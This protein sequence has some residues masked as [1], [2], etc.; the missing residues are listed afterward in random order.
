MLDR[1]SSDVNP[2]SIPQVRRALSRL[3]PAGMSIIRLDITRSTR[4]DGGWNLAGY[5]EYHSSSKK[6]NFFVDFESNYCQGGISGLVIGD[7]L[8]V[9]RRRKLAKKA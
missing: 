3:L 2:P 4:I 6:A 1:K 9:P 7:R 8:Y 5:I